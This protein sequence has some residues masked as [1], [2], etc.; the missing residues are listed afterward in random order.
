MTK[1]QWIIII[2]M[3]F[4]LIT[5]YGLMKFL[6]AQKPELAER[7]PRINERW[8]KAEPVAYNA[9]LSPFEAKGRLVSTA[10]VELVAEASGRIEAGDVPLKTGQSF[11]KGEVL[12][13][14]Y[15][16][17]AELALKARK[18]RFMNTVANLLPDIRVDYPRYESRFKSF[19]NQIDLE[20]PLPPLPAFDS[21]PLK[22]FL[23]SRN[24]LADYY[25]VLQA[26]LKLSRHSITAPFDGVLSAVHLEVGAY[27]NV[28]GRIGKMMAT[29]SLE[30]DVAVENANAK[31]IAP[32]DP[33]V[34]KSIDRNQTWQGSVV[35]V[36][37]FVDPATQSRS[38]FVHVPLK[39]Q[40]SLY[41]GEYLAAI[42]RGA[43]VR[44][45]MQIPR[46]ALFNYNEV[47]TIHDGLLKIEEVDVVKVTQTQALI[48]GLEP[49]IYIVMQPLIN[50]AE[51]TAVKILGVDA[52][53]K[54]EAFSE[55]P[56][57]AANTGTKSD[58]SS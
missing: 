14:I 37:E 10:E 16:D 1:R 8:V 56:D 12:F 42:F 28:G 32:G 36:S 46:N 30:V 3:I 39:G 24:I 5:S 48:R 23:A 35:R 49:E 41:A 54:P 38:V 43:T 34:L 18:S 47:F 40:A 55:N 44:N 45:V 4:I 57:A 6:I 11:K 51:N 15:K 29:H 21:E 53:D 52:P 50:V 19:F 2:A 26:E 13:T 17:E 27:T 58:P 20:S 7:P 33:V 25:A 9:V 31:W 22:I